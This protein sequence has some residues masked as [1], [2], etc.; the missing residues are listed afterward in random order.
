MVVAVHRRY[1][2]GMST[3]GTA[4]GRAGGAG[5]VRTGGLDERGVI[6]EPRWRLFLDGLFVVAMTIGALGLLLGVLSAGPSTA[7]LVCTVLVVV[8]VAIWVAGLRHRSHPLLAWAFAGCALGL[9]LLSEGPVFLM[10]AFVAVTVLTVEVGVR[11]AA[12]LAAT[13]GPL[14]TLTGWLAYHE[15]ADATMA[16]FVLDGIFVALSLSVAVLVG[17][18]LRDLELTRRAVLSSNRELALANARLRETMSLERD[19]VLAQ[20][21]ARSSRDLHDGLSARLT[22]TSM[23]L[24]YAQRIRRQEPEQAWAEVDRAAAGNREALGHMRLWVRALSPPQMTPGLGGAAAFEVIA[25]S[26]RGTGLSVQVQH[27]GETGSLPPPVATLAYRL[28]Q[29]GLTNTL[30]YAEATA[31]TISLTQSRHQVRIAVQDDG[32]CTDQPVEGFGLRG[33]RE[34]TVGLGGRLTAGPGPRGGFALTATLPLTPDEEAGAQP[35]R[36]GALA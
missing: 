17:A 32:T 29:E 3:V 28:V 26:F 31:V 8:S 10:L 20:E 27:E 5:A 1:S 13:S 23:S 15:H 34:H 7:A 21:R 9:A 16:G 25:D 2:P 30:R 24:D 19:L 12:V 36:S 11:P 4:G 22:L 33:L 6:T 35:V 18:L 14:L